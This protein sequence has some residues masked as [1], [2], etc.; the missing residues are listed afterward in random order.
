MIVSRSCQHASE[1]GWNQ[2]GNFKKK[3]GHRDDAS[4]QETQDPIDLPKKAEK[5]L[6]DD[7]KHQ[8][9]KNPTHAWGH[10]LEF[11]IEVEGREPLFS[12]VFQQ[13]ALAL[14]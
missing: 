7:K 11:Y 4:G 12:N 8:K 14:C 9:E 2:Q 13:H 5:P 1:R 6:S 3:G 10:S